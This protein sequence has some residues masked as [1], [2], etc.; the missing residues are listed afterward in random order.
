LYA[1]VCQCLNEE[2][3]KSRTAAADAGERID[4]LF[5]E[6]MG[7][8]ERGT[9]ILGG[10]SAAAVHRNDGV[11]VRACYLLAE[12]SL[13]RQ[14]A[15]LAERYTAT[16]MRLLERV[17]DPVQQAQFQRLRGNCFCLRGVYDKSSYYLLEAVETLEKQPDST[18][19]MLQLAAAYCDYGRVC[20]QQEDYVQACAY[21]K[22]ALKLMGNEPWPGLVWV[23]LHY[24][25]AAFAL[26]DHAKARELFARGYEAAKLTG[27][28]WGRTAVAA[29][30]AYYQAKDAEYDRA[31]QSL[32]DAQASAA[33]LNSPLEGVILCF[34]SMHIRRGL[35]L[36]QQ[37]NT[38]L[39]K[40]LPFSMDSYARQG[41]RMLSGIPDVFEAQLLSHSLRD[42][43]SAQQHYRA[44]ELY[45]KNKHFMVE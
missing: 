31:V 26:E 33:A 13:L 18:G 8:T 34:V 16:G 15:D 9:G 39:D 4:E 45:S 24:G 32:S 41:I 28:P 37:R 20:R 27:E 6:Q 11:Q 5:V 19:V 22:K 14:S 42:G 2:V 21:Y 30:T 17:R 36:E 3:G 35:D 23:Y 38:P 10:L 12:T 40:L 1:A 43:I 44:A 7:N 29:F 25:R